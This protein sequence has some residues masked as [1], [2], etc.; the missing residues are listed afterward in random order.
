MIHGI[1]ATQHYVVLILGPAT[2][3]LN[4]MMRGG[5]V[6]KWEPE[7]G[8]RVGLI[9]RDGSEPIR[10]LP[11]ARSAR[12]L[13]WDAADPAVPMARVRIPQRVPNGLHASWFPAT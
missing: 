8:T 13:V 4:A 1:A 11:A 3:D 9:R 5:D 7:L 10:W 12:L 2:L 6:L